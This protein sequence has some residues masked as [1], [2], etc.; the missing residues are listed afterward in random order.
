[1][2]LEKEDELLINN[3]SEI[4][5]I[6][7]LHKDKMALIEQCFIDSGRGLEIDEFCKIMLDYLDYDKEDKQR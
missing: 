7:L 5:I 3:S 1:L 2:D 4:D 6:D